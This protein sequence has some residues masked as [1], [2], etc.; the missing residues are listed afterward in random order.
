M[1]WSLVSM[2]DRRDRWLVDQVPRRD[3][4]RDCWLAE[5]DRR[6]HRRDSNVFNASGVLGDGP[7][8]KKMIVSLIRYCIKD[9][10]LC[11]SSSL[12]SNLSYILP[13]NF[14]MSTRL[15][16]SLPQPCLSSNFPQQWRIQALA[17]LAAAPPPL[18]PPI[19]FWPHR[20]QAVDILDMRVH[21]SKPASRASRVTHA[22]VICAVGCQC[23]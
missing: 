22:A 18:A 23:H 1:Q 19:F 5:R 4:W 21:L 13:H 8:D 3:T 14:L 12:S 11:R 15:F 16:S 2:P 17:D 9:F 7:T 6:M 10:P 20:S